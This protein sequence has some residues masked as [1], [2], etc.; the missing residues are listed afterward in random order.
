MNEHDIRTSTGA[1]KLPG[2]TFGQ[3]FPLP[4]SP[5]ERYML[6]DDSNE[7][8]MSFVLIVNLKGCL[9]RVSFEQ[10]ALFAIERHPLLM[11]RVGHVRGKGQ[12]WLPEPTPA[13][14]ID[15]QD[16]GQPVRNSVRQRIDLT[17][18]I[19]VRISVNRVP[20]SA[21][22]LFEFH[23]ACTDGIGGVQFIGDLLAHY[24]RLTALEGDELPEMEAVDVERLRARERFSISDSETS[25]KSVNSPF[26]LFRKLMKLVRRS[27]A[28]LVA[29]RNHQRS[30]AALEFPAMISR[31]IERTELQRLKVVAAQKSVEL[32]D[33]YMFEMFQTLRDWNRNHSAAPDDQWLRIGMPTSLRTPQHDQ[34]P[35]ANV[36]SYMF[37]TR[38]AG[39][40]DRPEEMLAGIHRQTSMVVNERLG[41]LAVNGL[42]Y[43]LKVPGLLWCLLRLNRCFCTAILANVGDIR[44]QFRVRFPLKQG[45]CVAG[46]V[47]LESLMGSPPVRPNTRL[48]TSMGTYGGSLFINLHCDPR[49]FSREQ[50]EELADL[51]VNRLRRISPAAADE[52]KVA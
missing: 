46:N 35:A 6:L 1:V 23:H 4:I 43:V 47:V 10:S 27:P 52:S 48:S 15:W 26:V 13:V 16:G 33:L 19:G 9:H 14:P 17:R 5:F 51:F 2:G 30:G 39:D 7:Y 41:R 11:S 24:A 22:V 37:L 28:P 50:A 29:T 36:V 12:C 21:E 8:P 32:N 38:R 40:F 49:S 20:E 31:T 18:E 3:L 42:R 45:K 44:R 34:M 25:S